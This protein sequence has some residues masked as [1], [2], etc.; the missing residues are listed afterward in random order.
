MKVVIGKYAGFCPGVLNSVNKA[1]EVIEN[2]N[3]IYCLGELIHNKTVVSSLE[4]KGMKTIEDINDVPNGK[5]VL[6]RAHGVKKSIY[7][8]AKNKNLNVIDLTCAIVK[9]IHEKVNEAK[10][11][12]FI[13][14]TGDNTHPETIGTKDFA[15]ENSYVIS[16]EE[17]VEI[18]YKEFINSNLNKIYVISQTT[19]SLKK[20][21]ELVLLIKDR[22]KNYDIDINN[23]I[24]KATE[25][26]QKEVEE[27]SKDVDSVIVVGG[28]NSSNTKKLYDISTRNC[29]LVFHIEKVDELN[30]KDFESCKKVA[31]VAG[32]S[33]PKDIINEIE[34]FLDRVSNSSLI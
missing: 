33:T 9:N 3:D 28:K 6:F 1:N 32:A 11:D 15:G 30:I 13:I 29:D 25:L 22:F 18:A 24:C 26:R 31:V 16:V 8:E 5:T 21:D 27:L 2:D 7:E 34:F 20:F 19:F 23:S 17:D 14:I 12:S 10:K 4:D